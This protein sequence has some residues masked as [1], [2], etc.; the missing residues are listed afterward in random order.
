MWPADLIE[1]LREGYA[2]GGAQKRAAFRAVRTRYPDLPGHMIVRLARQQGWLG[3]SKKTASPR[4]RWTTT[5]Q[6]R[7]AAMAEL[8]TV[9]QMARALGRSA[10]AI[11]WRLGAQSLSARIDTTWSLRQ[12]TSTFHVGPTTLRRWMAE[13][14]LRVCDAHITGDSLLA[15]RTRHPCVCKHIA[16]KVMTSTAIAPDRHYRWKDAARILG[17]HIEAV[18]QGIAHGVF[19]LADPKVNERALACFFQ[20]HAIER[21]NGGRIDQA[22][23]RWLAHEYR[24]PHSSGRG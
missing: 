11:R 17:C 24:L 12:M 20:R 16:R 3:I 4:R 2:H 19:K 9:T 15:Y 1:R 5:E 6:A 22:V 21:L 10:N 23:Y 13:R 7:F 14:A 18:R 8:R